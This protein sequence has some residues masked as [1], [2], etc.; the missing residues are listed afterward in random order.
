MTVRMSVAWIPQLRPEKPFT[1]EAERVRLGHQSPATPP[2]NCVGNG[3][4]NC[5]RLGGNSEPKL[6]WLPRPGA[7]AGQ[8]SANGG[9]EMSSAS[10]A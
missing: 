5:P 6:T 8:R 10:H 3:L 7:P 1:F 9:T 2:A 4:L